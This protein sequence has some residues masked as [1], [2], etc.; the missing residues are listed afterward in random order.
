MKVLLF[1]MNKMFI[2]G[3]VS[4]SWVLDPSFYSSHTK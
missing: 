3:S 4:S 1:V 2:G